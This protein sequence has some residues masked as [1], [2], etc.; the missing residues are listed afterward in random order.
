MLIIYVTCNGLTGTYVLL[1]RQV[2]EEMEMLHAFTAVLHLPNLSKPEHLLSVLEE[3]DVFTK[4]EI[5]TI[6]RNIEG[7]RYVSI[8]YT[9]FVHISFAPNYE[10]K[11]LLLFLLI[12][13]YVY[14]IFIVCSSV[15]RNSLVS[16]TYSVKQRVTTVWRSSCRS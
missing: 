9:F 12:I 11:L 14:G 5:A 7:R 13:Y 2:L 6:A 16:S 15:S 8:C 4:P 1:S 3:S 10:I